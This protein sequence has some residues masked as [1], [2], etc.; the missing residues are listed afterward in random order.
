MDRFVVKCDDKQ[1]YMPDSI[2]KLIRTRAITEMEIGI[3]DGR[4]ISV[5]QRKKIYATLRD[6]AEHTGYTDEAIKEVMKHEYMLTSGCEPF[7]LS[8]CSVTTA[9]DFIN[10][11]MDYALREGI[12]LKE[13]GLLRTDDIDHYLISCIKYK[14]CCICGKPA[15]IHHVDAI[16]MGHN[17]KHKD[18]SGSRIMA[19]CRNHHTI[20]HTRGVDD[21]AKIYKVYGIEKIRCQEGVV[22]GG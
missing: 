12:I 19:L 17:R 1:L 9:R 3:D 13:E 7:S 11:L 5:S 20:Y 22:N 8:T 21:F 14:R 2:K 18:D 6:I 16:G 15:E 10:A 4:C